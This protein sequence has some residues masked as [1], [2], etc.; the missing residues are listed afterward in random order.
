M[1]HSSRSGMWR[2]GF[3]HGLVDKEA[4]ATRKALA[5]WTSDRE[6]NRVAGRNAFGSELVLRMGLLNFHTFPQP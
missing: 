3:F 1:D 4:W 6:M 5:V 2:G